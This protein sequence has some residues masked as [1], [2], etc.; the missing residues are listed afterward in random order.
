MNRRRR[1]LGVFVCVL[2]AAQACGSA[3]AEDQGENKPILPGY[4]SYTASTILAEA[5]KGFQCVRP[6]KIDEFLEGPHNRHYK[7]TYPAKSVE[8]GRASFEGECVD[9][10]G[11]RFAIA[12]KGDYAPTRFTLK[13]H[14]HGPI[15]GIPLTLPIAIDAR[16]V[17]GECPAGS[18]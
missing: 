16:R 11:V 2:G 4:W 17:G 1:A 6:D 10:H 8:G 7:C 15:L 14:I 5:S 3:L 13:G 18:K 9:K 12:I